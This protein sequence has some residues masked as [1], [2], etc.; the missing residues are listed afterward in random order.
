MSRLNNEIDEYNKPCRI[1]TNDNK[2]I[3]FCSYC[4]KVFTTKLKLQ[5]HFKNNIHINNKKDYS[6][7][8]NEIGFVYTKNY[9]LSLPRFNTCRFK[10]D[11][12]NTYHNKKN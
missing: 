2:Y 6:K 9:I 4:E 3:Y 1:E 10:N 11:Y 8:K 12:L 7:R 5:N